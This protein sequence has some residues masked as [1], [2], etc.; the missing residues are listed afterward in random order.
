MR[1][2]DVCKDS[3]IA[4]YG[5]LVL[6]SIGYAYE[7]GKVWFFE[8]T[9]TK[10]VLFQSLI[11]ISAIYVNS[12]TSEHFL[13]ITC[14]KNGKMQ[15]IVEPQTSITSA[16]AILSLAKRGLMVSSK[17]AS[18][19]SSYLNAFLVANDG[20]LAEKELPNSIGWTNNG[21][22]LFGSRLVTATGEIDENA[23]RLF[24]S[25]NESIVQVMKSV[26]V[27]GKGETQRNSIGGMI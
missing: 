26:D 4:E 18:A 27:Q 11:F 15:N 25:N 19:L 21:E 13:Q 14:L 23:G 5:E 7:D 16:S 3:G 2:S 24:V 20:I 8:K 9:D 22:F 1:I 6:P 10:K 12:I 17:N